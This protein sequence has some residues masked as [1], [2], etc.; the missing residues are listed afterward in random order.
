MPGDGV[1]YLF[2]GQGRFVVEN[3]NWAKSFSNFFPGIAG[4]WGIPMWCYYVSRCQAV[5]SMGIRDK[6]HQIL[7][8]LPFNKALAQVGR[9][10]FRTF[11]RPSGRQVHE[12]F[13][14]TRN[15]KICQRLVVSSGEL[16]IEEK[17]D[18]M[19]IETTVAYYPLVDYP[20]PALIREV[21][22][23]NISGSK[24]D[25]EVADG[26]PH[27][28]PHGMDFKLVKERARHHEGMMTVADRGGVPLFRLKQSPADVEQV[29]KVTGGNFYFSVIDGARRPL[30]KNIVVD[31]SV[32][33][34]ESEI[35]DFPWGFEDMSAAE[36]LGQE[37]IRQNRT[38]CAFTVFP[39]SLNS[40]AEAVLHALI[41][42]VKRDEALDRLMK[43]SMR[44]DFFEER[45]S[46]NSGLLKGIKD[47]ALTVTSSG[48]FD[49]YCMQT[50]LDNV[51][52]GGMPV[53][54]DAA[55]RKSAFYL[56]SRQNGDLE[57]DYHYFVVEPTYLSQGTGHYRSV[58]QNRRCDAWFFPEVGDSNIALFMNLTQLDGYNPL[59][60]NQ[61]TY[62]A[63]DGGGIAQWLEGF[64]ADGGACDR[65][66]GMA[67]GKFA[68]GEFIMAL[69]EC[70]IPVKKSRDEIV[71]ELISF[72]DEN[73]VGGLH[74][75][76]FWV[77]HWSYNLDII[78]GYLMIYPERA[79]SLL[80]GDRKYTFFDNPDSVLPRSAKCVLAKNGVRRY[81]AAVHDGEKAGR[82]EARP[83]EKNKVRTRYGD[84]DVCRVD[85][86]TKLL[87][88]VANRVATLD[89][90]NVGIEMEANKPGW[91]DSMSGLPG[92]FGSSLC[93]LFE[94]E[95]AIGFLLKSLDSFCAA[96]SGFA[97]YEEL[98]DFIRGL[99]GAIDRRLGSKDADK[100]FIYWDESNGIKERYRART[101]LG[102]SGK[103]IDVP[104]GE[105]VVFLER[106]MALVNDVYADEN[107]SK[108]FDPSGI[109]HTYISYEVS[110]YEPLWEEKGNGL[111]MKNAEGRA[112][113][114]P[115][116]FR[117]KPLALFLEGPIHFMRAHPE[118]ARGIY[119]LVKKS[120][121]YDRK[122]KMY[123]VCAPLA[124][125][126][127]EIGRVHAW[128][129]GW[130]ENESV[131]T[132][133]EYKYLLELVKCGL[134]DEFYEDIRTAFMCFQ[135]PKVYG[136]SPVENVSFIV[137]SAFPD[138]KMHGQGLQPRL[139]GVTSE[140]MHIWTLLM[141][142][143][144]PFFV[145]GGGRLQ[146]KLDPKLPAWLFTKEDRTASCC[147]S[148]GRL[149]DVRVPRDGVAFNFLS[150][151]V[152]V[153]HNPSRKNTYGRD[154]A[155]A[156][157]YR[158]KYKDGG[159]RDV[160]G[161]TLDTPLAIDVRE[162]RVARMDVEIA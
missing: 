118:R 146:L 99:V 57:R 46:K 139:S 27:I 15:P 47:R 131:Y 10:G 48:V 129:A 148:D 127:F 75:L 81:D 104:A 122:L 28:I 34:G 113:V 45:R 25:F 114:L 20:V 110:S 112:L 93:Q 158:L 159:E 17:N 68:P 116:G 30:F 128:G 108:A 52:R 16:V 22:F 77:D 64:V 157:S 161:D 12:A 92:I 106:A 67:S 105:V 73:E 24:I 36:L 41:G 154:G 70:G 120:Q 40:G 132:H 133:M 117:A 53:V 151:A 136:R 80:F 7:E 79:K 142:G 94:L 147:D 29:E 88:H 85:L 31:P 42:F 125:E 21:K 96:D 43:D 134:Y 14:K 149:V 72:C 162:G 11:L 74:D 84:G 37:Q 98:V 143:P 89:P 51:M 135:D 152:V 69:E 91:N 63:V 145:D 19:G 121:M 62:T 38:P 87:C 66:M 141:A 49:E 23:K 83:G 60:V 71:R 8:F 54:F 32:L 65:L 140:M 109:P 78:E 123:K 153:Y 4:R 155:G 13:K 50:F 95:R 9:T 82:I 101:R 6:D 33:F 55:G 76:G 56:Y 58:L 115:R 138:E 156:K 124:D 100:R 2:D 90:D 144:N 111:G 107:R 119:E 26:L 126:S 59:E 160:D 1:K 97:I 103:E 86:F 137:S 39:L 35:Y 150:R 44:P 5:C 18:E 102:V 3:Y 130:I 61:I